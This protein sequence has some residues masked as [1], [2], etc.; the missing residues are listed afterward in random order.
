ML[1]TAA[2]VIGYSVIG[3]AAAGAAFIPCYVAYRTVV[4]TI[5]IISQYALLWRLG[6]KPAAG[7]KLGKAWIDSFSYAEWSRIG[8]RAKKIFSR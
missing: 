5:D 8:Y 1:D 4:A 7:V 6:K 2:Y 3:T